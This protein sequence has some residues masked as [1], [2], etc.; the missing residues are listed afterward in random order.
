MKDV[1]TGAVIN[2]TLVLACPSAFPYT[3]TVVPEDCVWAYTPLGSDYSISTL[4][5]GK[6]L[7]YAGIPT[8]ELEYVSSQGVKVTLT[9]NRVSTRNLT[10]AYQS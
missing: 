9:S 5:P 4:P 1:P 6:W 8:N 3:G 7:L 10:V 2:D